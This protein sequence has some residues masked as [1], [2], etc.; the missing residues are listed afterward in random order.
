M[1]PE[2]KDAFTRLYRCSI[3]A[4][5]RAGARA[6]IIGAAP[7]VLPDP[8]PEGVYALPFAPFSQV[9][10]RCA[11]VINHGGNYTAGEALRAGVPALVVPWG[12]DL[13]FSAAQVRRIGAG[14]WIHPRFYTPKT[15]ERMLRAILEKPQYKSA[16][17]DAAACMA[18]EDGAGALCDAIE[19][20][21]QRSPL[22]GPGT[23]IATGSMHTHS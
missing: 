21:L 14:L 7:G 12:I 20:I 1:A 10:P 13:F 18:R 11:A 16:A 3:T 19:T 9:Y 8:L 5:R 6:L 2:V 23:G 15:A 22:P 4:I 17:R